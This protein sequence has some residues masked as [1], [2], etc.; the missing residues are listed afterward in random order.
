MDAYDEMASALRG[1]EPC[2]LPSRRLGFQRE[3]AREQS[4]YGMSVSQHNFPPRQV[5]KLSR[6]LQVRDG[7]RAS[8]DAWLLETFG[9]RHD[10]Y[11]IGHGIFM[12]PVTYR[13]LQKFFTP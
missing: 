4:I 6:D 12:D 11:V 2:N 10:I 13:N 8:M 7:F 3:M 9:E 5:I 1:D